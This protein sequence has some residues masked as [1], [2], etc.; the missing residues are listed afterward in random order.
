MSGAPEKPATRPYWGADYSSYVS[1]LKWKLGDPLSALQQLF[2]PLRWLVVYLTYSYPQWII[3]EANRRAR[4]GT[5]LEDSDFPAAEARDSADVLSSWILREWAAEQERMKRDEAAGRQPRTPKAALLYV[6]LR[7]FGLEYFWATLAAAA[8]TVAK[9][10]EALLLGALVRWFMAWTAGVSD[11]SGYLWAGL[12]SLTVVWHAFLHHVLFFLSMRVG[13]RMRVGFISTIYRK[14][15]RLSITH[16][17]STGYI[18]NLTANDT[19]R[20]EEAAPFAFFILL[21]PL[22]AAISVVIMYLLIGVSSLVGFA[23]LFLSIPLQSFFAKRFGALRRDTVRERDERIKNISDAL[24]GIQV[25]KLYGWEEAMKDKIS[26]LR[27]AEISYIRKASV[28]RALNEAMYIVTPSLTSLATFG[29]YWALGNTFTADRV[30]VTIYLFNIVR[31]TL[32]NFFS[33]AV[34]FLSES[35][36]S[37]AR[38]SEFLSLPEMSNTEHDPEKDRAE[39]ARLLGHKAGSEVLVSVREASFSWASD[40]ASTSAAV[41][42]PA[43]NGHPKDGA[44]E[45]KDVSKVSDPR[46]DGASS[47][48]DETEGPESGDG[49]STVDEVAVTARAFS[50]ESI[51]FVVKRGT[52]TAIVGPVG[53]G[54]SSLLLALLSEMSL[55]KGSVLVGARSIALATQS[56]WITNGTVMDNI[57]FG[58]PYDEKRFAETVE[59]AAMTRDLEILPNGKDTVI[60]D[61]GVVLSGGQR[62]RTALARAIYADPDLYLLDDPLSAVDSR[63]AKHLW[64]TLRDLVATK[65]KTVII[66]THQLQFVKDADQVLIMEKGRISRQ[67]TWAEI[68]S[69]RVPSGNIRDVRRQ[70]F[71]HVLRQYSFKEAGNGKTVDELDLDDS[72]SDSEETDEVADKEAEESKAIPADQSA[73]KDVGDAKAAPAGGGFVVEERQLGDVGLGVWI[74][75]GKAAG[76]WPLSATLL[77]MLCVGEACLILCDWWLAVWSRQNPTNQRNSIYVSVF[78]GLTAANVSVAVVRAQIFFWMCLTASTTLFNDMLKAILRAPIFFFQVNPLGRLLNRFSKDIALIDELLPM[79]LYDLAQTVFMVL[80][81]LILTAVIMPISLSFIPIL[82][83]VFYVLRRVYVTGSRQIKRLEAN[84]RSPVYSAIPTTLEGLPVIRAFKAGNRFVDSFSC[85]QDANTSQWFGFISSA[86]WLGFRLDISGAALLTFTAF[87]SAGLVSSLSG[88]TV[89]LLLAYVL[90]LMG[91]LQWGVRQS[92][93]AENLMVSVER[94]LDYTKVPQEPPSVTDVRPPPDW[95]T[96]GAIVFDKM[97]LT[98]PVTGQTVL[99]DLSVS[100]AA[101]EKVGL[102]GR[103][104][105]GKSSLLTAL[106]RLVE[107]SPE[108]S[109]VIDGVATSDIGLLDL[110]QNLGIVPQEPYLFKGTLRFNIDPFNKYDDAAIWSALEAVELKEKVESSPDKLEMQVSDGG[111]NWSVGERQLICLSR[112]LMQRSRVVVMDEVGANIDVR[113]DRLIQTTLRSEEGLFKDATV[114]TIAHRLGTVIDYDRI[115]VLDQGN[116]VEFGHPHELLE[117]GPSNGWLARM[118][119]DS[120]PEAEAN[121]KEIARKKFEERLAKT[122]AADEIQKPP[123]ARFGTRTRIADRKPADPPLAKPGMMFSILPR[124]K[125]ALAGFVPPKDEFKDEFADEDFEDEPHGAL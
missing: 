76:G 45:M 56:P 119:H 75:F 92:V 18:T 99:K 95:P 120:G 106:F 73:A 40:Q 3:I 34:Q 77:L 16:T 121:M 55:T 123:Q 7:I 1:F 6:M 86:R 85:L 57:L 74:A 65:G 46:P 114:I 89:G 109:V 78:A 68:E 102:V 41:S 48:E 31:L 19:Q 117:R 91:T 110:R 105:A 112:A 35:N 43:A 32:S 54:K 83:V 81:I 9:I 11:N 64:A 13:F 118:V 51:D 37:V 88:P 113:T 84:S 61:R 69:M 111:S 26:E 115:L 8:E 71:A 23:I 22:E 29:T 50:L 14:C 103:T 80:G 39:I 125:T 25:V 100:I 2:L 33:K 60:G 66:V 12:L 28:L 79:V 94:I 107:P 67:G 104:G 101:G 63:V 10:L 59:M 5:A 27:N 122:K 47:S 97:S 49:S 70:S 21:G 4:K 17:S 52:T 98:Y 124:G 72:E 42:E 62:A 82:L 30:F 90:Q 53:A 116:V 108:R 15:L 24:A 20:F 44:M 96:G 58:L 87:L 36:V 38:I 93:E